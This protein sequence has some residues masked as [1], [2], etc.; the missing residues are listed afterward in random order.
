[1]YPKR[2]EG[3]K[4]RANH[5]CSR[6]IAF[7]AKRIAIKRTQRNARKRINAVKI[8]IGGTAGAILEKRLKIRNNRESSVVNASQSSIWFCGD[9]EEKRSRRKKNQVEVQLFSK[10]LLIRSVRAE[11]KC[12]HLH[13]RGERKMG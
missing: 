1:M 8:W 13:Q 7:S 5:Y 11:A 4:R 9:T 10:H 12:K 6:K 2:D 3:E